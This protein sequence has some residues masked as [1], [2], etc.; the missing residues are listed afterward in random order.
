MSFL[1]NTTSF[2]LFKIENLPDGI[3]GSFGEKLRQFAF[4]PIDDTEEEQSFGWTGFADMEDFSFNDCEVQT[5]LYFSFRVD[6]RNIAPGLYK[7]HLETALKKELEE[8]A[9]MGRKYISRERKKEI[10]TQIKLKLLAK[11]LPTP[12]LYDVIINTLTHDVYFGSTNKKIIDLFGDYLLKT[13]GVVTSKK[14]EQIT[15][16]EAMNPDYEMLSKF[17]LYKLTPLVRS[18]IFVEKYIQLKNNYINLYP[19][20]FTDFQQSDIKAQTGI[21]LGEEFLTWLWY[22]ADRQT[23]FKYVE[24]QKESGFYAVFEN[25]VSVRGNNGEN[26]LFTSVKGQ[27]NPMLEARLGLETGKKVNTATI[28]LSD[29]QYSFIFSLDA[30]VFSFSSFQIERLPWQEKET[31]HKILLKTPFFERAMEYFNIVYEEFLFLRLD[32]SR[33][34]QETNKIKE[35]I[36]N[37]KRS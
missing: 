25:N 24:D 18:Q 30:K 19:T 36:E 5:W 3:L 37:N 27:N 2:S 31:V 6:K 33:W 22:Q 34:S 23:K 21:I 32:T 29:S 13:F 12:A 15:L 14:G 17:Q 8:Y 10:K 35:W 1:K 28:V 9:K 7:R 20:I 11:T 16:D 4:M 26:N